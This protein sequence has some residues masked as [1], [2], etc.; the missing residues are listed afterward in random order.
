MNEMDGV[1]GMCGGEKKSIKDFGGRT[2]G[3][4]TTW[5]TQV[6][7]GRIILTFWHRSFTFKF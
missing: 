3:K 7:M 6:K 1:C 4:E 2:W 5:K